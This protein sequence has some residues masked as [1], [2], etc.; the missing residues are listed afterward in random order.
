MI[1]LKRTLLTITIFF[2]YLAVVQSQTLPGNY[3]T[4]WSGNSFSGSPNWVQ[5]YML[6]GTV[7]PAGKVYTIAHWDEAGKTCGIYQNGNAVGQLSASG[8][9]ITSNS[10]HVFAQ[11]G[12]AAKKFNF[13]GTA[14]SQTI[15]MTFT[16]SYLAANKSYLVASDNGGNSVSVFNL[17]NGSVVKKW[18]VKNPGAVAI[19]SNNMV[20]IVSGVKLP[21]D[22][23]ERKWLEYDSTY[24]PRV[25][26]Y[27]TSG[28]KQQDSAFVDNEWRPACLS[29]DKNTNQ[30]MVGDDGPKHQVHFFD[31]SGTPALV[32]S[33]GTEGGISAGDPGIITPLK[34]WALKGIGTD[35]TGNIFVIIGEDGSMIRSLKPTGELNWELHAANF[36]DV[37]NFDQYSDGRYLYGKNEIVEMDYNK[38]VPGTEWRMYAYTQDRTGNP[39]DPRNFYTS[40]GHEF[41][42]V[43]PRIIEGDMYMF[44]AGMYGIKPNVL[45]FTGKVASPA[46]YL[47]LNGNSAFYQDK[48]GSVWETNA[49]GIVKTPLA[50]IEKNGDLVYGKVQT[51]S[52]LPSPFSS[53]SRIIYDEDNDV[54]YLK[55]NDNMFARY[56]NWSKG[57]RTYAFKGTFPS[58][59]NQCVAVAGDYIF[60]CGVQTRGRIKVYSANDF[61]YLGMLLA[62]SSVGGPDNPGWVDIP[63]G[64]NAMKRSNGEYLVALEDDGKMK[65]VIFRWCPTGDCKQGAPTV[66]FNGLMNK[67]SLL[68]GDSLTVIA[69]A[70]DINGSIDS[71]Q[72]Y[73]DKQLLATSKSATLSFNWKNIHEGNYYLLA[74]AYDNDGLSATTYP[75]RIYVTLP[76]VSK[77]SAPAGLTAK[78][79]TAT[80]VTL[81]WR[82]SSDDKGVAG[83]KILRDGVIAYVSGGA[84]TTYRAMGLSPN[85]TYNFSVVA[86]DKALNLSDESNSLSVKTNSDGPY[87]GK[88][89]A[90]PG[91]IEVEYFDKGGEGIAYHDATPEH[92]GAS[93]RADEG[94][95]LAATTAGYYIGW[96]EIGEWL[97][98]T[99]DVAKEGD[100]DVLF[101]TAGGSGSLNLN[102]SNGDK[103]YSASY[104]KTSD[105]NIWTL[106]AKTNIHLLPGVQF[107]KVKF[108]NAQ[109]NLDYI[110]IIDHQTANQ[111][112]PL[113]LVL[114]TIIG[115]SATL[116]WELAGDASNIKEYRIYRN[117][118][119]LET[120]KTRTYIAKNLVAGQQYTFTVSSVSLVG[121][122]S[123]KSNS[124]V[125]TIPLTTSMHEQPGGYNFSVYPNPAGSSITINT[126]EI[127]AEPLTLS[128]TDMQGNTVLSKIIETNAGIYSEKVD[129]LP[130]GIYILKISNKAVFGT[131]TIV[132]R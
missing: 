42:S 37:L 60:T 77:P 113:N 64:L 94:I 121:I 122:E 99:V 47:K 116:A 66:K 65:S 18:N 78:E 71:I 82:K 107:L 2:G 131:Q 79:T 92:T 40:L 33:F 9:A 24:A 84:D 3:T 58:D 59:Y 31:I 29:I 5:G 70:E 55:G 101:L 80:Y 97:R 74:K 21:E 27:N 36:V 23:F 109:F 120:S 98:F 52:S 88:P 12:A 43:W 115:N 49:N 22:R 86:F 112:T 53:V 96:T 106:N 30:L 111:Q 63:Y 100:Y 126:G 54:M 124:L 44:T 130:K 25:Y 56:N 19:D 38:T 69:T 10:T 91:N 102:F 110:K 87:L 117:G 7:S 16:P 57:N 62:G 34:F 103:N 35:A 83:Y 6:S 93:F 90:I 125:V 123:D 68:P 28:V 48:E 104:A 50:A 67:T 118:V 95:D 45:K 127:T 132:I 114:D 129:Q 32:N 14:T 85:K 76:D 8:F 26:K 1:D 72:L 89:F 13:D 105:W 73:A 61:T 119:F 128:L 46:A 41:T 4:T 108:N 17:S 15:G 11:N 81:Q 51:V 75:I 39:D 20:W